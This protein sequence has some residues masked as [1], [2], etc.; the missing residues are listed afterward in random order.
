MEVRLVTGRLQA[1]AGIGDSAGIR[2]VAAPEQ[3]KG[4]NRLKFKRSGWNDRF[5]LKLISEIA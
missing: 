3:D 4:S 1:T 5:L 2:P